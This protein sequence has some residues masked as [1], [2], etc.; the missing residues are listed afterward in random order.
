M[1]SNPK[2]TDFLINKT[3]KKFPLTSYGIRTHNQFSFDRVTV[4]A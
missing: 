4:T 2:N 3:S 1:W